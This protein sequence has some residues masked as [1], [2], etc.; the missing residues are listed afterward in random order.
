MEELNRTVDEIT[1]E[2][3]LTCA[4]GKSFCG[5]STGYY[6]L[7]YKTG[8]FQKG[9]LILLSGERKEDKF[10]FVLN[11]VH[12]MITKEKV[13]VAI[14][15]MNLSKKQIIK[16]LFAI[17]LGPKDLYFNKNFCDGQHA[18]EVRECGKKIKES[19]LYIEDNVY[20]TLEE[21]CESCVKLKEEIELGFV[22]IDNI[23]LFACNETKKDT[24]MGGSIVKSLKTL[25]KDID[26]P[27]LLVSDKTIET[28]IN[29]CS[30]ITGKLDRFLTEVLYLDRYA[31]L[32]MCMYSDEPYKSNDPKIGIQDVTINLE[33]NDSIGKVQLVKE[34]GTNRFLNRLA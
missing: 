16:Q 15:S 28:E 14:F 3:N 11:M 29:R 23:Q 12:H 9:E 17:E 10:P 5:I 1:E 13:P 21:I 30:E 26:S 22:V 8:G 7:D 27:L 19:P 20:L 31:D 6:E 2:Y 4:S 32:K 25:A 34:V 33:R 24:V 18:E